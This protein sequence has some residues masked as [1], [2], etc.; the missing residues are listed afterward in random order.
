MLISIFKETVSMTHKITLFFL[1]VHLFHFSYSQKPSVYEFKWAFW[2]PLAALKVKKITKKCDK[3]VSRIALV[4]QLDS[5][6]N[7][8][9]SDAFRHSFFMAAY[10]QK[11]KVK[12]L[13]KLGEAHEKG[14]YRQF[15]RSRLENGE[16]A[17][18]LGTAMD[19]FNNELGFK[20]GFANKKTSLEML[21]GIIISEIKTGK[22]VIMKR[23][24]HGN[25]L[26]CEGKPVN[27]GVYIQK[28]FIPKCLV[29]SDYRPQL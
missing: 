19:L 15:L 28:W 17:D 23:D 24:R 4:T 9:K 2:H 10:T 8:G 13:R 3:E 27:P 11:I 12:K 25:Y 16:V 22:A 1:F 29:A 5:F 26:D 18:S 6:N 20:I 21:S 7:G 14:N